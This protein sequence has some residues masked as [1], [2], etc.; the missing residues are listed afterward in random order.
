MRY[1]VYVQFVILYNYVNVVYC[2]DVYEQMLY[3]DMYIVYVLY[4]KCQYIIY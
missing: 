4:K 1:D 3:V 2:V